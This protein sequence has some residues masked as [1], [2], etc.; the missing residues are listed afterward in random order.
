MKNVYLPTS[1]G[2]I[3]FKT[4]RDEIIETKRSLSIEMRTLYVTLDTNNKSVLFSLAVELLLLY[5]LLGALTLI[6]TVIN[7]THMYTLINNVKVILY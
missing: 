6:I 7:N 5:H 1:A 3:N 4:Q 2:L